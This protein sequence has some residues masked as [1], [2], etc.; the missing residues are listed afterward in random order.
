MHALVGL[1]TMLW[2]QCDPTSMPIKYWCPLGDRF[3]PFV[4]GVLM[5]G[6]KCPRRWRNTFMGHAKHRRTTTRGRHRASTHHL[7]HAATATAS[8]GVAAGMVMASVN[9]AHADPPINWDAI[10]QCESGGNWAINTGNG[11]YGGLQFALSTWRANGGIGMPQNAS[12]DTQI[13]VAKRVLATQ[14]IGAWPVCGA[15]AHSSTPSAPAK[16]I[17]P[18]PGLQHTTPVTPK[19]PASSYTVVAGDTLSAIAA[20]H[21]TPGGWQAIASAN[22]SAASDPNLIYPGQTLRLPE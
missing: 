19:A 17:K 7:R 22:A 14:G 4:A 15:R 16:A 13:A 5:Q 8:L 1:S 10:A 6:A 11:Y 3:R 9:T 18:A 12:R 20:D 21:H 2:I